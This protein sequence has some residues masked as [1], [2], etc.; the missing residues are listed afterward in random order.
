MA[1][2]MIVDDS[3]VVRH[4]LSQMVELADHTAIQVESGE[5]ALELLETRAK[6]EPTLLPDLIF[7]D[8]LMSPGMSG[9]ETTC[10]IKASPIP[11]IAEVPVVFLTGI[12]EQDIVS[13]A[14]DAG[15]IDYMIKPSSAE[16]LPIFL[17]NLRKK[18]DRLLTMSTRS[19]KRGAGL[20]ADLSNEYLPSLLQM[21]HLE[22][23]SGYATLTNPKKK[24]SASM[25][26]R[27]GNIEHLVL[28]DT[29]KGV[30]TRL[31]GED[32]FRMLIKWTEGVFSFG[33]ADP[34]RMPKGQPMNLV[35]LL[36]AVDDKEIAGVTGEATPPVQ[37][38]VPEFETYAAFK[39]RLEKEIT[40]LVN[41][42]RVESIHYVRLNKGKA[43]ILLH[44]ILSN[45]SV[46]PLK[47]FDGKRELV[48]F[49]KQKA[50][51]LDSGKFKEI[52]FFLEKGYIVIRKGTRIDYVVLIG[53]DQDN[54][55]QGR[56]SAARAA[57]LIRKAA[58]ERRN[59]RIMHQQAKQAAQ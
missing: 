6:S 53:N 39:A 44:G 19:L 10:K 1:R 22:D 3:K 17:S 29:S 54:V 24:Q 32:A 52:F 30:K 51:D 8:V 31:E 57:T 9:I 37:P 2:V 42:S 50:P 5:K 55:R 33:R 18:L 48:S 13:K 28:V 47:V 49:V 27:Y 59:K 4:Y 41:E 25:H 14:L 38:K 12:G 56:L 23:A 16:S 15:A 7:M 35:T 40:N 21:L 36:C 46:P 20:I 26:I 58:I 34:E 43:S 45:S 11:A